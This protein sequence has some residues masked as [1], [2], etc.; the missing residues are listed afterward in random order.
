MTDDTTVT[1][2]DNAVAATGSQ[3]AD[4]WKMATALS[5]A[6]IIPKQYQG[7]AA[8]CFVALDM[9]QRLGTGVM[10]IMQNTYVVHGT[11]GFS[12]K[13]VIGMCN[14][15]GPF[16]G[17]IQFAWTPDQKN[18]SVTAWAIV[19]ETGDR[20]EFTVDMNMAK[21]EGWT[22]NAKYKTLPQSM[23]SYRAGVQLVRLYA[24]ETMLGM[25]TA[26]EL[27]DARTVKATVVPLD[28]DFVVRDV[29][30][31]KQ[32]EE[33]SPEPEPVPATDLWDGVK[34]A[35]EDKG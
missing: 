7:Q 31:P 12:A 33:P 13:Y 30:S 6:T 21:A 26:E 11:P 27:E 18:P 14:Q 22:S 2:S 5:R 10:E 25:Q 16:K 24:P 28:Q 4:M 20:V 23:L 9:A 35:S 8:N 15:R 29:E 17:P 3:A 1:S 32:V 19:R 34:Q